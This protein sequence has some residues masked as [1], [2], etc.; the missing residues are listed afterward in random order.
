MSGFNAFMARNSTLFLADHEDLDIRFIAPTTHT[1]PLSPQPFCV[2]Y[3]SI[4]DL[5]CMTWTTPALLCYYT[6]TNYAPQ[7]GYS[8]L[9]YPAWRIHQTVQSAQKFLSL[10]GSTFPAGTVIRF[11]ARNL[12]THGSPSLWSP[13]ASATKE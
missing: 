12:D 7:A 13:T 8:N 9:K 5:Y 1:R 4:T 6:Q 2:D 11:R 3:C 10:D